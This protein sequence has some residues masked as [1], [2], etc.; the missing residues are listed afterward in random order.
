MEGAR[1][2]A[3]GRRQVN[4]LGTRKREH[5]RKP[6]E[7]Y[8]VIEACSPEPRL[9]LF[10]RGARPGWTAWGKQAEA[11]EIGWETY[12]HNSQRED[13]REWAEAAE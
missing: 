8:G 10:A 6:D 7:F 5:S 11:Y 4:L 13:A 12:A 1:T 3:P 9:E 2:P